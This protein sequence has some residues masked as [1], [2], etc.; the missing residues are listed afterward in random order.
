MS[1]LDSINALKLSIENYDARIRN[2]IAD[3]LDKHQTVV[4]EDFTLASNGVKEYNLTTLLGEKAGEYNLY[5]PDIEL[6]VK[7]NEAAPEVVYIKASAVATVAIVD[8]GIVR[9]TNSFETNLD[10]RV[11][12]DVNKSI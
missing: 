4:T 3:A 2:L 5:T 10:F 8:P 6:Y 9:I 12:I 11:R 7:D 1:I